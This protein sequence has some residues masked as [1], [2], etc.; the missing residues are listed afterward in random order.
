MATRSRKP[1]PTTQDD[2]TEP[3]E[4]GRVVPVLSRRIVHGD[5]VHEA[6]SPAP[7]DDPVVLARWRRNGWID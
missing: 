1:S 3:A 5:R 7:T 4:A 2:P 6:G